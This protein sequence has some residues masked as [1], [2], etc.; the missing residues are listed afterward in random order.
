MSYQSLQSDGPSS[1]MKLED[2]A[3]PHGTEGMLVT[4]QPL[5]EAQSAVIL[6]H[7]RGAPPES[8]LPLAEELSREDTIFILPRASGSQWYPFRFIEKRIKNEPGLTSALRLVDGIVRALIAAG[9]SRERI[10]IGGFSQGACLA[11]DYAAL[12]PARY[13]GV[14][15]LS[16]GLIGATIDTEGYGGSL[17]NTPV[18]IGCSNVDFHIPLERVQESS[19]VLRSL[20]AEVTERIYPGMGHTVNED[21]LKTIKAM[22]SKVA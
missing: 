10:F 18:F 15:A 6:I 5:E 9:L 2:L 20:G 1:L 22:L 17:E 14:F 13:G 4:G 12:H 11:L 3:P 19:R 8:M 7:G 21:E 16:G